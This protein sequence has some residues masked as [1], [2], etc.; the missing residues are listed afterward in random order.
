MAG[1]MLRLSSTADVVGRLQGAKEISVEAYTLP[2]PIVN[3]LEAAA[4]RGA[5]VAVRVEGRP[6]NNDHLRIEN[7][8][9]V[10]ELRET[11]VDAT[12]VDGTHAK[13][14]EVDGT[15]YLDEKNWRN[16]DIVLRDDDAAEAASIPET[17]REALARE[18]QLLGQAKTGD[19]VVVESESFGSGNSTYRALKQLGRAGAAPRLLVSKRV[20]SGNWRERRIL[21]DLLGDGVR[22]RVCQDS[23]KLGLAG[24]RAWLGSANA[25]VT[26]AGDDMTDWGLCTADPEI[27][28]AVRNRLEVEWKTA[29]ELKPLSCFPQR[30]PA[31][32][33]LLRHPLP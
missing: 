24:N 13:E 30:S 7:A 9:L 20:L 25:T 18:A 31:S 16:D 22:V 17:K 33:P 27:V 5:R 2:R 15:L 19:Q 14:I 28:S 4:Q 21:D 1:A 10:A 6:H 3:A 26:F 32:G 8:R 12:L 11:G 23:A 29:K